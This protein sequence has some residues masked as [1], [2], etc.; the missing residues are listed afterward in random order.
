MDLLDKQANQLLTAVGQTQL[1]KQA[2][3]FKS[4]SALGTTG[5]VGTRA[6]T[7]LPLQSAIISGIEA[8]T[9][10]SN[11]T[12]KQEK[13]RKAAYLKKRVIASTVLSAILGGTVGS[14]LPG[15]GEP[16]TAP[17]IGAAAL[18]ALL[19]GGATYLTEKKLVGDA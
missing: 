3:P 7:E 6:L 1:E 19:G 15:E 8:H 2:F 13:E 14:L 4:N 18:G 11:M 12:E 10:P 16:K 9:R 5:V 17:V